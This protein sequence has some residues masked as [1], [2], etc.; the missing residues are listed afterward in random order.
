MSQHARIRIEAVTASLN[1]RPRRTLAWR[2]P[3]ETLAELPASGQASE[4]TTL[5]STGR[6]GAPGDNA[7]MASF[8]AT[9]H[10]EVGQLPRGARYRLRSAGPKLGLAHNGY[11]TITTIRS[12]HWSYVNLA[13]PPTPSGLV[14]KKRPS[15]RSSLVGSAASGNPQRQSPEVVPE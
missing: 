14:R 2:T 13:M 3:A 15:K 1:G 9:V 5:A 7:M 8:V 11:L 12:P 6:V 4:A 10:H